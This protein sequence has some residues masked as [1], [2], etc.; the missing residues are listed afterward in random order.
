[1]HVGLF[2]D[3][4]TDRILEAFTGF[5][6]SRDRRIAALGPAALPAEQAAISIFDPPDYGRI[7]AGKYFAR[8]LAIS[9]NAGIAADLRL[10]REPADAAVT[11]LRMPKNECARVGRQ[12]G[13][14]G[15]QLRAQVA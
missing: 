8:A 3:F 10:C 14:I 9:A 7:D 5:D 1:M 2:I 4:A 13:F 6:E 15:R 11:L 12:I